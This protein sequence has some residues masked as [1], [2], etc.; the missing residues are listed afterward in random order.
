MDI[1]HVKENGARDLAEANC[2][3]SKPSSE[4][5]TPQEIIEG[6]GSARSNEEEPFLIQ[7]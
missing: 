4:D 5:T 2:V 7:L 6:L 1:C 3:Q